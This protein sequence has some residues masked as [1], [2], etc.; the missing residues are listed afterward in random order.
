M[1]MDWNAPYFNRQGWILSNLENLHLDCKEALVVVLI[2]FLNDHH[3]DVTHEVLAQKTHLKPEEI[4]S[5]FSSLSEKGYL[6]IDFAN[7]HVRF[8]LDGLLTPGQGPGE[9]LERSLI[10]EFEM[11]FGRP[12]SGLEME[13]IM[14]FAQKY[15]ARRVIVA[16]NEAASYDQR[17][18]DYIERVLAAWKRKKLSVEDLENGKR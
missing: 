11:E 5:I 3:L 6:R 13:R 1:E 8:L 7:G 18:L 16:L 9:V 10:E 17:S 12:L 2:E 14:D 4:E 15:D